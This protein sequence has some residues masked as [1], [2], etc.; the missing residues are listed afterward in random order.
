MMHSMFPPGTSVQIAEPFFKIADSGQRVVRCDLPTDV[1]IKI[2]D[3]I[4]KEIDFAAVFALF[5][6]MKRKNQNLVAHQFLLQ[7]LRTENNPCTENV[8]V[9]LRNRCEAAL[10]M[11]HH[12]AALSDAAAALFLRPNDKKAWNRYTRSLEA[13]GDCSNLNARAHKVRCPT[14]RQSDKY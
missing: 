4:G 7:A 2:P 1:H 5:L 6:R 11:D 12:L 14:K 13:R 3:E 8:V 10:K 9:L